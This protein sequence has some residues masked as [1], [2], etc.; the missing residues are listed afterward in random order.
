VPALEAHT[1]T[2]PTPHTH[3]HAPCSLAS[4][5][6][7]PKLAAGLLS[8]STRERA[9]AHSKFTSPAP[10]TPGRAAFLFPQAST[11]VR[12]SRAHVPAHALG[13]QSVGVCAALA[14]PRRRLVV[15]TPCGSKAP[16]FF[17]PVAPP[18]SLLGCY[19]PYKPAV[20]TP[21]GQ[22]D[23]F[24]PASLWGKTSNT[25]RF[26]QNPVGFFLRTPAHTPVWPQGITRIPCGRPIRPL[27]TRLN[28]VL[29]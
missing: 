17:E 16:P 8:L 19:V 27:G 1:R 20:A 11:F 23:L 22:R 13:E 14:E 26:A 24:R 29:G 6:P 10:A 5:R 28:S 9:C 21:H 25:C 4:G 3:A 12:P 15:G 7:R 2:R 18:R